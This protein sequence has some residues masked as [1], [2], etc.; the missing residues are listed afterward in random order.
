MKRLEL[1][2][3]RVCERCGRGRADLTGDDGAALTIPLDAIRAAELSGATSDV[4][5]L[6][7]FVL[8]RLRASGATPSEVVFDVE[9]GGLRA[10]VASRRGAESDVLACTPQEGLDLAIRG[11]LAVYATDDAL[12]RDAGG[13]GTGRPGPTVH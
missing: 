6:G 11:G 2:R 7:D 1:K 5:A 10:L 12:R 9:V 13:K 3:V 8:D 4:R